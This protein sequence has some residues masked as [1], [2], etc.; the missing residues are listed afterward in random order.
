M[1]KTQ[2]DRITITLAFESEKLLP[3]VITAKLCVDPTSIGQ[4]GEP[5]GKTGKVWEK[6]IWSTDV[7][8][9]SHQYPG[10]STAGLIS[11]ALNTF[12][13]KVTACA[14][15]LQDR[16]FSG[17]ERFVVISLLVS[18]VPGIEMGTEFLRF[19]A[20]LGATVQIEF[21]GL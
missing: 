13:T 2:D 5:R 4:K 8:V 18:S 7:V 19:V 12:L 3:D 9:S 15:L 17:T 11:I 6:N 16:E 21:Y 20:E 10:E 14:S 1:M